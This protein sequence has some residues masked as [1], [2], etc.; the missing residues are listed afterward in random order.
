M[1]NLAFYETM[2]IHELYHEFIHFHFLGSIGKINLSK[3]ALYNNSEKTHLTI[4][5]LNDKR[6]NDN[7]QQS[8]LS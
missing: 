6:Q 7:E 5:K 3:F 1:Q 8:V 2:V 4:I